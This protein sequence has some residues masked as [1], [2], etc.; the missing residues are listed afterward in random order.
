M[1]LVL[2]YTLPEKPAYF[3]GKTSFTSY[4]QLKDNKRRMKLAIEF[5]PD[6]ESGLLLYSQGP[7]GIRDY[8]MV[9][10]ENRYVVVRYVC[11][12]VFE[13]QRFSIQLDIYLKKQGKECFVSPQFSV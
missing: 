12:D 7:K 1:Y 11:I 10:L 8:F 3:N 13:S 4:R 2:V 9:A 6:K 5:R